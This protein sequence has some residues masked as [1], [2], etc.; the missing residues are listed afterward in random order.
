MIFVVRT[1]SYARHDRRRTTSF[2]N[3]AYR[4][5]DRGV[6]ISVAAALRQTLV[7]RPPVLGPLLF[8]L[9]VNDMVTVSSIASTIMFVDDTNL[10]FSGKDIDPPG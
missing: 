7:N 3:K 5:D 1:T 6:T 9:Y 8:L 4:G 2:V 10:F